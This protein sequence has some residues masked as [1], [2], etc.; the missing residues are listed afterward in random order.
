MQKIILTHPKYNLLVV[1][2]Y[3]SPHCLSVHNNIVFL[4]KIHLTCDISAQLESRLSPEF[5]KVVLGCNH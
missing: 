2:V 4:T 1:A 3:I 5:K